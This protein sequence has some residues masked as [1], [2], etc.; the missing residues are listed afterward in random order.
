MGLIRETDCRME[1]IMAITYEQVN[2]QEVL[3]DLGKICKTVEVCGSCEGKECLIGYSKICTA[4]CMRDKVTYVYEGQQNMPKYDIRGGYDEYDVLHAIA[5]LLVQCRS[6]KTGH[7]DNCIINVVRNCL[8]VI[9][10]GEEKEFNGEV[11]PYLA[12]MGEKYSAQGNI[13]MEEYQKK[14]RQKE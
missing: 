4:N 13:I 7:F 6:C 1:D 12:A 8:E 10:F 2:G 9:E 5:H 3:D 11:L 14:K